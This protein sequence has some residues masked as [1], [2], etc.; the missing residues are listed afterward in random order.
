MPNP[1]HYALVL[2]IDQYPGINNLNSPSQDAKSFYDWLLGGGGVPPTNIEHIQTPATPL[3]D[4]ITAEPTRDKVNQAL[5]RLH[6][7]VKESTATKPLDW[8]NSRLYIYVSGHGIAPDGTE[9]A[10]LMANAAPGYWAENIPCDTYRRRYE[11][12]QY[13]HEVVI[14]ADCCR[15]LRASQFFPPPFNREDHMGT[16]NSFLGF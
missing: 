14:F 7:A 8:L 16:V 12:C 2:G 4:V 13:F 5:R 6:E 10:L 9:A 15:L 3:M 11:I 1:L